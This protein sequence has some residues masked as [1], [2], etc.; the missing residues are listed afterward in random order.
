M[1]KDN[2]RWEDLDTSVATTIGM[3]NGTSAKIYGVISNMQFTINK[4]LF[5]VP[6]VY[7]MDLFKGIEYII[8]HGFGKKYRVAQY[9]AENAATRPLVSI[10]GAAHHPHISWTSI[11]MTV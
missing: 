2:G 10:P 9:F 4:R 7:I 6:K 1:A 3:A 8:G 11:S 5:T